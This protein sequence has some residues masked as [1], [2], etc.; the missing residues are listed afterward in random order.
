MNVV[1]VEHRREGIDIAVGETEIWLTLVTRDE[2][3]CET[4]LAT[5]RGWGYDVDRAERAAERSGAAAAELHRLAAA[6]GPVLDAAA[7]DGMR[8]DAVRREH[9][10]RDHGAR[11]AG[12]DRDHGPLAFEVVDEVADEA[13][14]EVPLPAM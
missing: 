11:T 7:D 4:L 12:A 10:R 14:R 3:H 8:V 6:L 1:E 13:V 2:E 9:A 5:M